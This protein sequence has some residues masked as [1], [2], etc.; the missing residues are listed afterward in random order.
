MIENLDQLE[1]RKMFNFNLIFFYAD[2]AI[3][4]I[5]TRLFRAHRKSHSDDFTSYSAEI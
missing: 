2:E 4:E 3:G 5:P 1:V